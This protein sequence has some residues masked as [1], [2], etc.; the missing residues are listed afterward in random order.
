MTA[1]VTAKELQPVWDVPQSVP[2]TV[3][4]SMACHSSVDAVVGSLWKERE[5]ETI[6]RLGELK[7]MPLY[8]D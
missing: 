8:T 6:E 4:T 2:A 7:V 1:A 3:C 5:K